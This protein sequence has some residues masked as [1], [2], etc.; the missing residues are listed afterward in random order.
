[1]YQMYQISINAAC[2]CCSCKCNPC[3]V[4]ILLGNDSGGLIS[5]LAVF[6]ILREWHI[7]F[8]TIQLWRWKVKLELHG[9]NTKHS[10]TPTDK[11]RGHTP[12]AKF[13]LTWMKFHMQACS[14]NGLHEWIQQ[15]CVWVSFVHLMLG[16]RMKWKTGILV[17]S[18]WVK[19]S[20]KGPEGYF[21]FGFGSP[22]LNNW[23]DG[24][25]WVTAWVVFVVRVKCQS[26]DELFE[27]FILG[28]PL[29]LDFWR[30]LFCFLN[31]PV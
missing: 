14:W 8:T 23:M 18:Y 28:G 24:E 3:V 15:R 5:F 25:G 10:H 11:Q 22:I 2:N 29:T 16:R 31:S 19:S 27:T 6:L 13:T 4:G 20:R 26:E 7:L 1:M 9:Y 21:S 12:R 17:H 30:G